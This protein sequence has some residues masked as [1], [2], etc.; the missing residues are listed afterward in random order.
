M[1]PEQETPPYTGLL[2]MLL[3]WVGSEDPREIET[4]I[5]LLLWEGPRVVSYLIRAATTTTA[6]AH[7]HRLLDL[8]ARI[9]GYRT[10][11]D[12]RHLRALRKHWN[13]DIR[14][15]VEELFKVL[16]P[17]RKSRT[18]GLKIGAHGVA[19]IIGTTTASGC[20]SKAEMIA[21]ALRIVSKRQHQV[22]GR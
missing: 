14:T 8:A 3:D 6:V 20:R 22:S 13:K 19:H 16:T 11:A 15:K 5:T 7:Q 18:T 17:K 4:A 12:N 21:N 10:E 1:E 9:G 2:E